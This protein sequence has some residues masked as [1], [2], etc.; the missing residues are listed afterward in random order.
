MKYVVK[1]RP[2]PLGCEA[3]KKCYF[4]QRNCIPPL[5]LHSLSL[6]QR[7]AE[8]LHRSVQGRQHL[9][10]FVL[11]LLL[12]NKQSIGCSE[13]TVCALT[14][15]L[16]EYIFFQNCK[17]CDMP[18]FHQPIRIEHQLCSIAQFGGPKIPREFKKWQCYA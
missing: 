16:A 10:D 15:A 3:G 18:V 12:P 5:S 8:S 13:I 1:S 9:C 4:L 11:V 7:E 17:P 2:K 14:I 6:S